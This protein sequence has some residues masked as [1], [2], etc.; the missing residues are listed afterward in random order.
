MDVETELTFARDGDR[1]PAAWPD[2][3]LPVFERAVTCSYASLT[4]KRSP[5]TWAVT[6]FPGEDGRTIDLSTGL[7]YPLKAERARRNPHV[8]LL[9]SDP[10]GTGLDDPPIVLVLG[11]AT[12]RDRD[13]QTNSD[14]YL[15]LQMA[16]LPA[17]WRGV[18]RFLIR[19]QSWYWARVWVLITP[20]RILWW[21][22]RSL[23]RAPKK[24]RAPR[25]TFVPPSDPPPFGA[26]LPRT[27]G[28]EFDTHDRA[29]DALVRFGAPDLTVVGHDRFPYPFPVEA[30]GLEPD[31]FVLAVPP[32]AP[33]EAVGRACLTFH[34]HKANFDGQEN[35]VFT[36]RCEPVGEHTLFR[37]E[38]VLPDFSLP[39]GRVSRAR[40]FLGQR[41][42]LAGVL[43]A[44]CKRRGGTVPRVHLPR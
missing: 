33:A 11:Q 41:R 5:V 31:G 29:T 27:P 43:E 9:F 3:V 18:P 28:D 10:V 44:E 4:S 24:W 25:T 23:D 26:P 14:R 19:Q 16:K 35:A 37:I 30:V 22:N 8:A 38:K 7:T 12:V 32:H 36:G 1:N 40:A 42:R 13:L 39:G 20:E 34:V 6:P 15:R 17:A 2:A 21:P